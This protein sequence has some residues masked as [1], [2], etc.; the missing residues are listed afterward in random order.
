M[1]M[2]EYTLV[3]TKGTHT[4]GEELAEQIIAAIGNNERFLKVDLDIFGTRKS[5]RQT[6]L[7]MSHVVAITKNDDKPT[8]SGGP[9]V[10]AINART[11]RS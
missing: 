1:A 8:A 7:M 4:V 10:T 11:R 5:S 9:N 2:A 6:I 3:L